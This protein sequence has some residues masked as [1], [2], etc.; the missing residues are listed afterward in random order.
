VALLGV[1]GRVPAG[2][3]CPPSIADSHCQTRRQPFTPMRRAR[4]PPPTCGRE[5]RQRVAVEALE[6]HVAEVT[7]RVEEE[8]DGGR[9]RGCAQELQDLKQEEE[10]GMKVLQWVGEERDGGRKH[11]QVQE[12]PERGG[13]A[14]RRKGKG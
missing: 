14:K 9:K 5:P 11:G 6:G 8:R 10:E 1:R 13:S 4:T 3:A 2:A 12:V 7:Q